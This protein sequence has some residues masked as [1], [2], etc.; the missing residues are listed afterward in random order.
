MTTQQRPTAPKQR[1][2]WVVDAATGRVVRRQTAQLLHQVADALS[3]AMEQAAMT[4]EPGE[5]DLR[6]VRAVEDSR[7]ETSE[8]ARQ[9]QRS[10]DV[11]ARPDSRATNRQHWDE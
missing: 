2:E 11:H 9:R 8:A 10:S 6:V 7:S 1:S 4:I 5:S 3:E